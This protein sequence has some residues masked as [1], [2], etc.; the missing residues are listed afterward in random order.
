M[1]IIE[2]KVYTLDELSQ[3]AKEAAYENWNIDNYYPYAHENEETLKRFE[4]VFPI[5][6]GHWEYDQFSGN[7]SYEF[8]DNEID[9]D[10]IY[11]DTELKEMCGIR[12]LKYLH[13]NYWNDISSRKFYFAG[14]GIGIKSKTRHSNFQREVGNC[15]FT[16]YYMDEVILK[17]IHDFMK[18][19][20]E[21]INFNDL[22]D[23]CL[24]NWVQACVEDCEWT[25]S[26][27]CF[28]D[29]CE[30]NNMEFTEDGEI[31]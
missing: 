29:Y 5:E 31:Y 17:P 28:E 27:E 22:M 26:M 21:N 18:K 6:I 1:R 4:E 20:D 15:P 12:L 13:N 7:I 11:Y 2:T 24:N 3:E 23:M 10:D 16:G 30:A 14:G 8:E 9:I 25:N 19:P